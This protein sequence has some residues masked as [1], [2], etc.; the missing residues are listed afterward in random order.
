MVQKHHASSTYSQDSDTRGN[1]E[2]VNASA[3][4]VNEVCLQNINLKVK[5]GELTAVIGQV[6]A[7]KTSL[8]HLILGE[9]QPCLGK[10]S[11]QGVVSYAA[12]EPWL[13]S[14]NQLFENR[15]LRPV[16]GKNLVVTSSKFPQDPCVRTFS[17]AES[18]TVSATTLL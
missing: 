14:G 16:V 13:F 18:M 11:V 15:S 7:G 8:L 6:G 3:K 17:S 4:F 2:I 5:S 9:I 10:I 12:Q 1:V